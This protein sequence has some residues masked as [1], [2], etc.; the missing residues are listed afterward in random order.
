MYTYNVHLAPILFQITMILFINCKSGFLSRWVP[1]DSKKPNTLAGSAASAL[2]TPSWNHHN[3]HY[4]P[5]SNYY[6]HGFWRVSAQHGVSTLPDTHHYMYN[7]SRWNLNM[8]CCW[9]S[10]SSGV[11]VLSTSFNCTFNL[12]IRFSIQFHH[13]L[14][15]MTG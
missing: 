5:R 8:A 13:A 12:A 6:E 10:L 7:I 3:H 4:A 2:C 15:K 9:S 11:I 14:K 1:A